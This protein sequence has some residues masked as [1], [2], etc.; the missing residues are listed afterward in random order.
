MA[1]NGALA[2]KAGTILANRSL[3]DAELPLDPRVLWVADARYAFALVGQRLRGRGFEA[4]VHPSAV[5]GTDVKIGLG[6]RVGPGVVLEEGVVVGNDCNLMARAVVHAG[7]QLGNHVVVQAGAV[8]GSTGFGYARN[9]K[10]GQYLIFP[11]KGRLVIEDDVEIGANTTIDRGALEETRIA[12]GVKID[13]LVHI[14]HNVSVGEDVVIAAQTGISGSSS[15]HAGAVVG[16]QV[17]M[18]D[19]ASIG[20]GV[21]VGSQAGILPHKH[22]RGPGVVFWG[23]PAKPLRAYLKELATLARLTRKADKK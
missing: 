18:G 19:H 17:G 8:L 22:L 9:G 11:Q 14:G 12:R 10:T 13:N 16:G 20:K 23:T 3:E 6:T 2:S 15:I 5:V 1:L 7:T 4:G 21:I